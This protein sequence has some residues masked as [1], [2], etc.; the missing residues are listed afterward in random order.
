MCH[1]QA[2]I[3]LAGHSGKQVSCHL[4]SVLMILNLL[5]SGIE[6]APKAWSLLVPC[7]NTEAV[8]RLG[9]GHDEQIFEW[10]DSLFE[11]LQ[12]L[13]E[14]QVRNLFFMN[15]IY[16]YLIMHVSSTRH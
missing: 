8:G 2:A 5:S 6:Q 15:I 12:A 9:E 16:E 3:S 4:Y 10:Q 11:R 14:E 7:F 1:V 13:M